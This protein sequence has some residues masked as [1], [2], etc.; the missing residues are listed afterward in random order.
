MNGEEEFPS[1]VKLTIRRCPKLKSMPEIQSLQHLEL[2]NWLIIIPE[3]LH[4]LSSLECL[5][6]SE[7]PNLVALPE[8]QLSN[9]SK[10][11]SLYILS[12]QKLSF[13]PESL[14]YVTSLQTLEIHNCPDLKALLGWIDN[15]SFLQSLVIS[16]CHGIKPLSR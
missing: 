4:E 13:L 6:I 5:E 14:K 16:E 3:D 15:L 7:C 8:A 1:L 10:L 12:C 2:Q 9:L 11:R